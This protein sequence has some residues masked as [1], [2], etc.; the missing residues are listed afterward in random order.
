MRRLKKNYRTIGLTVMLLVFAFL[1]YVMRDGAPVRIVLAFVCLY[2][3]VS[4]LLLHG[5]AGR[6]HISLRKAEDPEDELRHYVYVVI[7]NRGRLPVLNCR[8]QLQVKNLITENTDVES[9]AVDLGPK[10]KKEIRF[11]VKDTLC[12]GIRVRLTQAK[13]A[14]VMGLMQKEIPVSGEE[15]VYNMP[16][17]NRLDLS[18]D[19]VSKYDM[20][21]YKYS[22][23]KK[24]NDSS[25]TFGINVYQP[26]DSV[27]SIHWKLSGKMDDIIIRELG[28]PIDHKL[29]VI[30]D[31]STNGV[32]DFT[33]EQRSEA[34]EF[35]ASLSYSLVKLN[36]PH[37]IGWF[38]QRKQEFEV[39]RVDDENDIWGYMPS[40]LTGSYDAKLKPA[41]DQFI[42]ADTEKNY[43]AI[44]LVSND[45]I[46]IERLMEYGEVHLYR[47]ENFRT[48]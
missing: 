29:M 15:Y 20:E 39:F 7:E 2:L 48:S 9:A 5:A 12:G 32:S 31:K 47:P 3:L 16:A 33:A 18:K 46:G 10:K 8:V 41:A 27:K 19:E 21:S 4:K 17:L 24:G 23:V 38:N 25:E 35:A 6:V 26:G 40:L 22:P 30:V 14:D 1:L 45:E 37:H 42:E 44:A 36:L 34:T 13:V 28:L 43:S 11:I